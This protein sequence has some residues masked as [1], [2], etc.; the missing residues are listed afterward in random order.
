M[1]IHNVTTMAS[2]AP[3][4]Y[5]WLTYDNNDAK[6]AQRSHRD[7]FELNEDVWTE[8]DRR[9]VTQDMSNFKYHVWDDVASF[10]GLGLKQNT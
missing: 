6:K 10:L 1:I 2:R 4:V 3:R 7:V 9:F 5:Q 8:N